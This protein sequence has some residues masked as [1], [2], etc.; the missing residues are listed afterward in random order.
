MP[1][2]APVPL[3]VRAD[4][5]E[6]PLDRGRRSAAARVE[7]GGEVESEQVVLVLDLQL[8]EPLLPGLRRAEEHAPP[9][10]R[11]A[12]GLLDEQEARALERGELSAQV[13]LQLRREQAVAEDV[14]RP[15]PA[16][17]DQEPVVDAAGRRRERLLARARDGRAERAPLRSGTR[18]LAHD[19][20]EPTVADL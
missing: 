14:S 15:G 20:H 17:L 9:G 18:M 7:R 10:L 11:A 5:E 6:R 16:V 2:A 8:E 3:A 12:L 4:D 1:R 19:S 13:R